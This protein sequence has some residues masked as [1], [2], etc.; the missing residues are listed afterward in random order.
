MNTNGSPDGLPPFLEARRA[1]L[2]YDLGWRGGNFAP[3]RDRLLG[4]WRATLPPVGIVDAKED[5]GVL[6]LTH[7]TGAKVRGI[8]TIPPG[9][10]PHPVALLFH[11]HG[12]TFD[13]GWEKL[14]DHPASLDTR[15]ALYGGRPVAQAFHECGIATLTCDAPCFGARQCGGY[16]GQQAF[17]ANALALGWSLAGI[18]ASESVG[19]VNWLSADPR[20]GR[21]GVF[22][23]SMGGHAAWTAAALSPM[24][25]AAASVGWLACRSDLMAPGQPLLVGHSAW[26][27]LLPGLSHRADFPDLAGLAADR[28]LFF[29]SG[30]NDRHMPEA[31]VA[32][33][34]AHL[35]AVA[36][37]AG[38]P[39]PDTAFHEHGHTC[40]PEVIDA[41]VGFLVGHL[42]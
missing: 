2:S 24:I 21:I 17:A 28:P 40:P 33:A 35:G 34:W 12:G 23:F 5:G 41:A 42:A 30:R 3:W 26:H 16:E 7:A 9:P 19:L 25:R 4:A 1:A 32:K 8:V 31:S 29:R 22:G 36:S 15:A 18:T 10:G 20:F 11:E 6:R 13:I 39:P 27:F 38:G 37:A 14:H